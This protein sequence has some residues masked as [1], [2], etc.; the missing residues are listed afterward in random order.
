MLITSLC[1]DSFSAVCIVAG[2]VT[3]LS[4]KSKKWSHSYFS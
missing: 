2:L 4:N 3:M 1:S